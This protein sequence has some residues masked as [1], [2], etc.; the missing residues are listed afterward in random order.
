MAGLALAQPAANTTPAPPAPITL[1]S[2]YLTPE[3]TPDG[4]TFLPPAPVAG[5]ELY[6]QDRR[7]FRET[8]RLSG[9]DRWRLAQTDN[10]AGID[11]M[12]EH[13][14]CALGLRLTSAQAP[15]LAAL[16][17][18]VSR[19]H[20]RITN[21]AKEHFARRRPYFIDEGEIC[22]GSNASTDTSFDY[23]SGHASWGWEWAV[24]LAEIAPD[25]AT[26]LFVRARAFG[27]SRVVCGVHNASTLDASRATALAL[28]AALHASPEFRA[29]LE[30]AR[31]EVSALRGQSAAPEPAVCQA[32]S[33]LTAQPPFTR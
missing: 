11:G 17:R 33:A 24:V 8:R 4:F 6:E 19:D 1:P 7:I 12:M 20:S 27:E 29:D 22:I 3:G 5:T 28:M 18:R 14:G 30:A 2:G 15:R 25:R 23:P 9:S 26:P 31:A 13:F 16:M 10:N 32:E 21:T